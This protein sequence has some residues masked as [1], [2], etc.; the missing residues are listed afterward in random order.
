MDAWT[1]I[2]IKYRNNNNHKITSED[3]TDC[4]CVEKSKPCEVCVQIL[5]HKLWKKL[6]KNNFD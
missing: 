3:I 1:S 4:K 2:D 5:R 6:W